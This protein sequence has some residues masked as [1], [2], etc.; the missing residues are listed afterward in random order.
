MNV[1]NKKQIIKEMAQKLHKP[2]SNVYVVKH[3]AN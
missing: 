3:Q 1:L 2:M